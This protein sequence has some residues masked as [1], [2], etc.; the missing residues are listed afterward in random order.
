MAIFENSISY[1]LAMEGGYSD[2]PADPGG[3]TYHG[4]SLRFLKAND[5]DVDGDGDIDA[6]DVSALTRGEV[7]DLYRRHFWKPQRLDL[8]NAQRI[9]TKVLD[10]VVN[11][12]LTRGA[13][14]AQRACNS[15]GKRLEVD[16]II[17]PKTR[18]AINA[19]DPGELL[20]AL[21]AEQAEFYT[22][23]VERRPELE[24]FR[25]GWLRRAAA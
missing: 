19:C 9:A 13:K 22:A 23:L 18:R 20:N 6:A 8:I 15:L 12:G 4:I 1:V 25:R 2:H 10:I 21:R 3:P 16:G 7:Y 11:T 24:V 5:V 14:L 17:G